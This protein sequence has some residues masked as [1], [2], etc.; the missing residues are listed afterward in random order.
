[1][2]DPLKME[3][4]GE[5]NLDK[6]SCAR[7]AKRIED[8]DKKWCNLW[9]KAHPEARK[10][11]LFS[12][13][14]AVFHRI[15]WH[16]YRRLIALQNDQQFDKPWWMVTCHSLNELFGCS[17]LCIVLNGTNGSAKRLASFEIRK[18]IDKQFGAPDY[19]PSSS[20]VFAIVLLDFPHGQLTKPSEIVTHLLYAATATTTSM[21]DYDKDPTNAEKHS[22][23]RDL[24]PTNPAL[25]ALL[26]EEWTTPFK[27]GTFKFHAKADNGKSYREEIERMR[28]AGVGRRSCSAPD[29][30]QVEQAER[31]QV[32]SKCKQSIYC[33]RECQVKH[34]PEHKKLCLLPPAR[35]A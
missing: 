32:C 5:N 33:S 11:I 2:P 6:G 17:P 20:L 12:R 15:I 26:H 35:K 10:L 23:Y 7:R 4:K 14:D 29:C 34:W 13:T 27:G 25:A 31:F 19:S 30:E 24:I 16:N 9:E 1:M 3:N 28:G 18:I 22:L 21:K 8:N